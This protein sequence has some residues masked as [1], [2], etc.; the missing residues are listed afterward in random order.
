MQHLF[1][2]RG[3]KFCR[4]INHF[5]YATCSP[6]QECIVKLNLLVNTASVFTILIHALNSSTY[7]SVHIVDEFTILDG[8]I[9]NNCTT[10][11]VEV[12]SGSVDSELCAFSNFDITLMSNSFIYNYI[13][14]LN[15]ECLAS[16]N[17]SSTSVEIY[18]WVISI[19]CGRC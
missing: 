8:T 14:S 10:H 2:Y 1:Q 9:V 17:C 3:Y 13:T 7:T 6:L 4:S 15:I 18:L 19:I 12:A 5:D 16:S 11:E